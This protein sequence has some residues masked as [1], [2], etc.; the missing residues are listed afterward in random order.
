LRPA[1][2]LA[3][4]LFASVVLAACSPSVPQVSTPVAATPTSAATPTVS[5]GVAPSPTVS[6]PPPTVSPGVAPSP[7]S[8]VDAG[9]TQTAQLQATAVAQA[10]Q[11]TVAVAAQGLAT[12]AA[13]SVQTTMT[14]IASGG[15]PSPATPVVPTASSTSVP[16]SPTPL[17]APGCAVQPVRGFALFYRTHP[18]VASRLGC[19]TSAEVGTPSSVQM[20]ENGLLLWFGINNQVFAL[21]NSG[22]AWA[23]YADS[24]Q[25]GQPLPTATVVAPAGRFAPTGRFGLVWEQQADVRNQLG[26]A[27]APEQAATTGAEEDFAHG[28]LWWT[29]SKMIYVLYGDNTWES[30]PDTFQG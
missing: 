19:P 26:W 17:A 29:P 23:A 5:P 25:N 8:V 15:A 22:A 13:Q 14:A 21:R 9:A 11:A 24:Y 18:P 6:A 20:F 12:A 2:W 16:P 7:T 10:V 28:H 3:A 30:F 27:T 1:T 4:I